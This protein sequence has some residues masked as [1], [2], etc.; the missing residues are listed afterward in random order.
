MGKWR[1]AMD[2]GGG[3]TESKEWTRTE[4]I[5]HF[6]RKK[7]RGVIFAIKGEN[8]ICLRRVNPR[9]IDKMAR[10]NR[11][12]PGGLTIYWL[13]VSTLKDLLHWRLARRFPGQAINEPDTDPEP[14]EA[15]SASAA[16]ESQYITLNADTGLDYARQILAEEK[17]VDRKGKQTWVRTRHDNHLLDCEVYAAACADSE[18]A[19]SLTF[20]SARMHDNHSGL[21]K[22]SYSTGNINSQGKAKTG[23]P[24][25]PAWMSAR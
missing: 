20:L 21:K 1:A 12:I 5:Y 14:G 24:K 16:V 19:P 23:N 18:W 2:T 4:E 6:V 11:P 10:G 17:Q 22:K 15:A 13:D 7:G 9:V 25:L 3:K 8:K